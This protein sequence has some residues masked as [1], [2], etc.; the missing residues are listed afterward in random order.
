MYSLL[1]FQ[2]NF[3]HQFSIRN[4]K[5]QLQKLEKSCLPCQETM[6]VTSGTVVREFWL[7]SRICSCFK[8]NKPLGNSWS[9]IRLFTDKEKE[10]SFL[11]MVSIAQMICICSNL[12][13]SSRSCGNAETAEGSGSE[14]ALP[15]KSNTSCFDR[16]S[17]S[18]GDICENK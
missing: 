17:R 18:V 6:I 15:L 4:K 10:I 1:H 8:P 14:D 2:M 11:R 3:E 16:T 9:F 7:R 13:Q 12:R 5:I